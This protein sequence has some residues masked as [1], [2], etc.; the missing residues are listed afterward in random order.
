MPPLGRGRRQ[1]RILLALAEREPQT[2]T[3]L[4]DGGSYPGEA[5]DRLTHAGF[6]ERGRNGRGA[7]EYTLTAHG[8]ALLDNDIEG[9]D[10]D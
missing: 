5:L 2:G 10:G 9:T 4:A 1:R 3:E 8:R 6:L 7:Y